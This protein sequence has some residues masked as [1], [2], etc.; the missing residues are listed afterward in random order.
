MILEKISFQA[1]AILKKMLTSLKMIMH[2]GMFED[3]NYNFYS[4]CKVYLGLLNA[5]QVGSHRIETYRKKQ[6][7]TDPDIEKNIY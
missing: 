3:E 4:Y 2:L 1:E 6:K 7:E 5:I